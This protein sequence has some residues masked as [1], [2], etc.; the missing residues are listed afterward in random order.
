MDSREE[1]ISDEPLCPSTIQFLADNGFINPA[2][3][4]ASGL[5][6]ALK[7]LQNDWDDEVIDE[8]TDDVNDDTLARM[9]EPQG[10][11]PQQ[12]A[13][14][15]QPT[16]PSSTLVD[17]VETMIASTRLPTENWVQGEQNHKR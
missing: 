17:E 6:A 1:D 5:R 3:D 9:I 15:A 11:N 2:Y 14:T 7:R 16:G 8:L 4:P 13:L 10:S 12:V